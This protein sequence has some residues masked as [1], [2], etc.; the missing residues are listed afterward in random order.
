M[1]LKKAFSKMIYFNND[2]H[3]NQV[4]AARY[5]GVSINTLRKM[6]DKGMPVK[7]IDGC[8]PI[9]VRKEIDEWMKKK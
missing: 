3:L 8:N 9:Y 1:D 6:E 2:L 7:R 4:E 5:L